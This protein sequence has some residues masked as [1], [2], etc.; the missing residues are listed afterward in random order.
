MRTLFLL[1]ILVILA[2]IAVKKPN[3]TAWDAAR[4]LQ[5]QAK[6]V[7]AKAEPPIVDSLKPLTDTTAWKGVKETVAKATKAIKESKRPSPSNN[8]DLNDTAIPAHNWAPNSRV[9]A[10]EIAPKPAVS[11]LP[12]IQA[13]PVPPVQLV[14]KLE[15]PKIS[16]L[17]RVR[18]LAKANYADVK[19]YYEQANRFLDDIK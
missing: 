9:P 14:E 13:V 11:P 8:D 1:G 7:I 4:D 17:A 19:V 10:V 16:P 3:Q 18:S 12:D 15:E 6:E 2:V 5:K